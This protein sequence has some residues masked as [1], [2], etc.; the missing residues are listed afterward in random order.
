MSSAKHERHPERRARSERSEL[1]QHGWNRLPR[2][3]HRDARGGHDRRPLAPKPASTS[4]SHHDAP[5][6][7]STGK[8]SSHS[9][10]EAELDEALA[11]PPLRSGR[12]TSKT[13]RREAISG[14][15]CAKVSRPAPRMTY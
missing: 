6:S 12:S 15:R 5:A 14:V 1:A 8:S 9:G 4:R 10:T 11:F 13:R 2:E 3:V 7:K